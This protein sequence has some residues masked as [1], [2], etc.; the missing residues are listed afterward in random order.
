M[1]VGASDDVLLRMRDRGVTPG[2][3]DV[4]LLLDVLEAPSDEDAEVAEKALL[5]LEKGNVPKAV[6]R[7]VARAR[8]AARP[9]R[10]RLTRLLGR[11]AGGS[12]EA[13]TFLLDVV[14]DED[15]KTR[16]AAA[17]ALGKLPKAD[18]I[19]RALLAAWDAAVSED[20]R[21]A[22]A[23]PLGKVGS[24]EARARLALLQ[25][26]AATEETARKAGRAVVMLDRELARAAPTA[27]DP[28]KALDAPVVVRFHTRAGLEAILE[29]E[30][31]AA[32][33]PRIAGP[34]V[35]EARLEGPLAGA[36]AIRTALDVGFPLEPARGEDVAA[37]IVGSLRTERAKRVFRTYQPD[38]PARFRLDFAGRGK[39]ERRAL[40]WRVAEL[41]REKG[42]LVND[43]H[44]ATWEVIVEES[45][46]GVALEIV[47]R[48]YE[49]TRFAYRKR[50]VPA[51]SSPV[52]AAA[53]ARVAPRRDDDVV[54]DP[55][56]GAGS[57]LVERA[58][59]GPYAKLIGTD[60]EPKAIDA[61]KAN[62][63][64]AGID[65]TLVLA[66]ATQFT[67]DVAPTL[68]L[69]N[70]PMGRRVQRGAHVDVLGRFVEHAAGLLRPGGALVL[71]VP[72]P[73][74]FHDR[75]ARAGLVLDR[76]WTIDM[77][78]FPAALSV[79][80]KETA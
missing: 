59:L 16:R 10:G 58:R 72:E 48:G 50:Q 40:A 69:T 46:G 2:L 78:G 7:I 53:L 56:V 11:F 28:T 62:L 41:V 67:P 51:S 37:T 52:L 33:R 61:A 35:V 24:P 19:A 45:D 12:D 79:F 9:G 5:R 4:P 55:F 57:E 25:E 32:W 60:L 21:R 38:G 31:G 26:G 20:D 71:P 13:R 47:P 75:A 18:D 77:G 49:D 74:R 30:L 29:D 64:A 63:A 76:T 39:G 42:D 80:R 65:A 36:L 54:W 70:P 27:I 3:K 6:T 17:R 14:R 1:I 43:P 44:G 23:E 66:D 15:P 73:G 22:L 68:V 8:A 34:G